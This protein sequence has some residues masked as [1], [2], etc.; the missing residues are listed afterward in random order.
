MSSLPS[1]PNPDLESP[2]SSP[3]TSRST[4]ILGVPD[5]YDSWVP[6]F[7][8]P[9]P[10]EQPSVLPSYY[11]SPPSPKRDLFGHDGWY[12]NIGEEGGWVPDSEDPYDISPQIDSPNLIEKPPR[13][14]DDDDRIDFDSLAELPLVVPDL[15]DEGVPSRELYSIPLIH[16]Y[17]GNK[18]PSGGRR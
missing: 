15:D 17:E 16:R 2:A 6:S 7:D 8:S 1:H 4:S 18:R 13:L 14:Q 9:T 11:D 3:K 5:D 12:D 10:A